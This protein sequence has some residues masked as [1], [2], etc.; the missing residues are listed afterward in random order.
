MNH[1]TVFSNVTQEYIVVNDKV[2]ELEA[3]YSI[4][5]LWE[6]RDTNIKK[7]LYYVLQSN[8]WNP[9]FFSICHNSENS[10]KIPHIH[11]FP[12][13]REG[14]IVKYIHKTILKV[15]EFF[16]RYLMKII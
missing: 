5:Q 8:V 11:V 13:F 7:P 12:T 1:E 4:L 10:L 14:N 6:L 3:I 9:H 16:L 15:V 2:V